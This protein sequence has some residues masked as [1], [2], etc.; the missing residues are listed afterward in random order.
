M[1]PSVA[2]LPRAGARRSIPQNTMKDPAGVREAVRGEE[3]EHY[4]RER[5]SVLR[6]DG[7]RRVRLRERGVGFILPAF[8]HLVK[9]ADEIEHLAG[10]LLE[11]R[12]HS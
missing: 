4:E 11:P 5:N 10:G 8:H 3:E 12:W 6:V 2:L 9:S 1:E 7:R